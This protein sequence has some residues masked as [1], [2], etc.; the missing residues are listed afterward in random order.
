MLIKINLFLFLLSINFV[1]AQQP[2]T[3]HLQ[4][5][6]QL[7]YTLFLIGDTGQP[8]LDGKDN[9]LN[10]LRERLMQAGENS[11]VVFL[12]DNVYPSGLP[13]RRHRHRQRAEKRLLEQLN[14][15]KDYPGDIFFIPGNHDWRKGRR[16]GLQYVLRQEQFINTF[17]GGRTVFYPGNGCPGPVEIHLTDAIVLVLMDT[18]WMFHAYDKPGRRSDCEYRTME[19]IFDGLEDILERNADKHL[20]V[21]SHHPIYSFG[22]HGGV[23]TMKQHI[24]PLTETGRRIY[25]PFPLIG[26]IYPGYRKF[27]GHVQDLN[28]PFYRSMRTTKSEIFRRFPGMIHAAGHEHNLQYIVRDSVHY[29]ISGSGSKTTYVRQER[30][31]EFAASR[32]GF[33]EAGFYDNG[34]IELD[35]WEA[36]NQE[37]LYNTSWVTRPLIFQDSLI[38]YEE[39]ID[40]S[41]ST[42][43]TPASHRYHVTG[44]TRKLLGENYRR[45]WHTPIDVPMFDMTGFSTIKKGGGQSTVSLRIEDEEGR[46]YVLRSID[47]NPDRALPEDLRGTIIADMF[48][49]QISANHP[50]AAFVLP[51]LASAAGIYHTNPQLVVIPDDPRLGRYREEFAN[52]LV[53]FEERPNDPW[54]GY[55]SFGS[56]DDVDSYST[57]IGHVINDH[58]VEI[59]ELFVVRNRLFDMIVG[60]WDRHDNQWRWAQFN[61]PEG[62]R[63][64]KP[65]PRDRDQVF[66]RSDGILTELVSKAMPQFQG[67]YPEMRNV[68]GFNYNARYFDRFFMT[69]PSAKDWLEIAED[70]QN[71]LTDEVIEEAIKGWP[72]EIYKLD[73]EMVIETLKAR[74]DRIK[75]YALE[76]YLVLA[77]TVNILG[78]NKSERFE[79]KRLNDNET[80]VT[81]YKLAENGEKV[82][83][84]Y[85]RLFKTGQTKE[86]RLYGFGGYDEFFVEGEVRRGITVRII[87]GE[88]P[89]L[90]EDRSRV[91]GWG[92]K[93]IVYDDKDEENVLILGREARDRTSNRPDVN[94][95]NREEFKRNQFYPLLLTDYNSEDGP[96]IGAGAYWVTHGFRKYPFATRHVIS[97]E[98]AP[99]TG[100]WDNDYRGEFV[101]VLG[102]ND[103]VVNADLRLPRYSNFFG[104]GNETLNL[105]ARDMNEVSRRYYQ[106]RSK[107]IRTNVLLRS[108]IGEV[109]R[110]FIGPSYN[111]I[112]IEQQHD[113]VRFIDNFIHN[114]E[115]P[116]L[117]FKGFHY[118]G[119]TINFTLDTRNNPNFTS[120]GI[121]YYINADILRG[122]SQQTND[123][124]RIS[125]AFSLYLTFPFQLPL[126]LAN[127]T[128]GA[129]VFG[130]FDFFHGPSLGETTN[131]RGFRKNRFIGRSNFFNNTELRVTLFN[132][133]RFILPGPVGILGFYDVGR[134]WV[135]K[136]ISEKWHRGYGAGLWYAP[137]NRVI[138]SLSAGFST[139]ESFL[140]NINLNYSL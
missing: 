103:I 75:E 60:D 111:F 116:G 85:E 138:G 96:F 47:K 19:E 126:T 73:G 68:E 26:S 17:F 38:Y 113:Q 45:T 11:G 12:G 59:D 57:V 76:Y 54:E 39:L 56:P 23:A 41:D 53:M 64:Y 129:T 97:A 46:D 82:D 88:G 110:F 124:S 27:L 32:K 137:F 8:D 121:F 115:Y 100:A 127:R 65:I 1:L 3:I 72:E 80:L 92:K 5:T 34:K 66:F 98:Y 93:T 123:L 30:G 29:I 133:R 13:P 109:G 106:V 6:A 24:F 135:D 25:M 21:A 36:N 22:A 10:L 95:Y 18:Q 99:A 50:Y 63:I 15:L 94:H 51:K 114:T 35:F 86:I 125:T 105:A 74:R 2:D 48:Q 108:S 69:E 101:D 58:D 70:L 90:I 120:T 52:M 67:F 4:D 9:N 71:R 89:D 79:V 28:H 42:V 91:H 131:L 84:I 14:I 128:G 37:V 87:G 16:D 107:D 81:V 119:A 77:E 139:E 49:D 33:V 78:S 61:K 140:F 118:G 31:A 117:D 44:F 55:E 20:V 122:L 83:K 40:F 104:F 112:E 7:T 134:V 102:R 62:G 43:R 136:E 132:L 130:D